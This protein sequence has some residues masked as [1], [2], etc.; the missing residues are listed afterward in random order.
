M[1]HCIRGG[2]GG[3]TYTILT[4]CITCPSLLKYDLL[5]TFWYTIRGARSG[6]SLS[7]VSDPW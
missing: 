3:I 1:P 7:A 6:S 4:L 5:C 2:A